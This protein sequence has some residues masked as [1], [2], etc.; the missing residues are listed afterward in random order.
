MIYRINLVGDRHCEYPVGNQYYGFVLTFLPER[1]KNDGFVQAV[2][3]TG[4][5]IQ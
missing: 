4:G 3:I 1:T 2:Q 5:F